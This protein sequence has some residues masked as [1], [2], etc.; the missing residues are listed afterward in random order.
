MNKILH[1]ARQSSCL[2]GHTRSHTR[3]V[4]QGDWG[5]WCPPPPPPLTFLYV[6]I[7]KN[8]FAFSG[9]P[10]I[11]STI[12]RSILWAGGAARGL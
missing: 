6:A 1:Q 2:L 7:F 8:D 11:F 3:A 12:M 5:C 4:V 9:K 10:L